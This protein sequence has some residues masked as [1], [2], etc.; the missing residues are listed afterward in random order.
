MD[1]NPY[2]DMQVPAW[3][4]SLSNY[5]SLDLGWMSFLWKPFLTLQT[6]AGQPS[7]MPSEYPCT[8]NFLFLALITVCDHISSAFTS[9]SSAFSIK[10]LKGP[11][12]CFTHHFLFSTWQSAGHIVGPQEIFVVWNGLNSQSALATWGQFLMVKASLLDQFA[13]SQRQNR[14]FT[15][16]CQRPITES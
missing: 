14:V 1:T 10:A 6:G 11:R 16:G 2:P 8:K 12:L 13:S 9:L 3:Y 5:H 4:G 15:Q 7:Y